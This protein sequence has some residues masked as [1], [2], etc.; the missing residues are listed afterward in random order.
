MLGS[1]EGGLVLDETSF[2]KKGQH[3]AG[4]PSHN[5]LV[6]VMALVNADQL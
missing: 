2:I 1:P 4:V 3:S 6:R 5:T